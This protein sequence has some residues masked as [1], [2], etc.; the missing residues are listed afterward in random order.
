MARADLRMYDVKRRG[1][2]AHVVVALLPVDRTDSGAAPNARRNQRD[3][4]ST[5]GR[6]TE[7]RHPWEDLGSGRPL[8]RSC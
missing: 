2:A 5:P 4:T 7:G 8:P 6:R 3:G 1:K